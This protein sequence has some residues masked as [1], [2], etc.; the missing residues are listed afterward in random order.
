MGIDSHQGSYGNQ[1]SSGPPSSSSGPG[2]HSSVSTVRH[3]P[4]QL[5]PGQIHP[6]VV[7]ALQHA[8]PPVCVY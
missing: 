8:K 7:G 4:Q 2:Q 1:S 6:V 5:L 3:A